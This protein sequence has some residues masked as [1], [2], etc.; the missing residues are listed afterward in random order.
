MGPADTSAITPIAPAW[1]RAWGQGLCYKL[2]LLLAV[3]SSI[4]P[5]KKFGLNLFKKKNTNLKHAVFKTSKST[6]KFARIQRY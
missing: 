1:L 6:F 4:R 3:V 5:F 2:C